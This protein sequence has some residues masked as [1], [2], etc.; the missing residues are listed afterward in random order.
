MDLEFARGC[1]HKYLRMLLQLGGRGGDKSY[2]KDGEIQLQLKVRN[3]S[4]VVKKDDCILL[5]LL[6]DLLWCFD[7]QSF[8][9]S[10]SQK[11]GDL[12]ELYQKCEG[13]SD[14]INI[15][16]G[17]FGKD[18]VPD[19]PNIPDITFELIYAIVNVASVK[20]GACLTISEIIAGCGKLEISPISI[21]E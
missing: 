20:V 3:S 16:I 21:E 7:S 8:H 10:S 13:K 12:L 19:S 14:I 17:S 2:V 15:I 11:L 4:S 6:I 5:I 18:S 1:S 9:M